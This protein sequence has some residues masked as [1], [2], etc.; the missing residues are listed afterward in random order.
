MI[1]K[2]FNLKVP[3]AIGEVNAYVCAC[4]TTREAMLVDAGILDPAVVA[5]IEE[6]H[7]RLTTVFVTHDHPDHTAGADDYRQKFDAQ[8]VAG[9]P[10]VG[11]FPVDRVMAHGDT[12][13]VGTLEARAVSTPGHTPVALSLIFGGVAFTGDALFAG[14]VGGTGTPENAAMQIAAIREH[15]FGLPGD[16]VVYSGH[17]PATTIEIERS[18]NPFFV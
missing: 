7:L 3:M 13:T 2:H 1:V 16:T 4:E 12:L 5:Y 9:T 6:N 18:Y 10:T 14:S 11:D 17:G 8:L 15:L